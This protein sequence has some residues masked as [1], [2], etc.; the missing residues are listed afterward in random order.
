MLILACVHG[1]KHMWVRLCRF[2]IA[3]LIQAKGELDW[4]ALLARARVVGSE[5][6]LFV[7]LL[8]ASDGSAPAF[9]KWSRKKRRE[10]APQRRSSST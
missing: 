5:R 6:I 3:E 9:L 10:T 7:G 1:T 8:L 2:A 4:D